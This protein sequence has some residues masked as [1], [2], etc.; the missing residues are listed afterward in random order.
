M[1]HYLQYLPDKELITKSDEFNNNFYLVEENLSAL[2][3]STNNKKIIY[4]ILSAILNL[5]NIRFDASATSDSIKIDADSCNSLHNAAELLKV[6]EC[7]L[8]N[9]LINHIREVGKLQIK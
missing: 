9:V 1:S 7:E 8:E 5:G 4:M 3:F 2:G 6:D